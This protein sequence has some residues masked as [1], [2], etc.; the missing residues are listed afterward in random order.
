MQWQRFCHSNASIITRT[1]FGQNATSF[2]CPHCGFVGKSWEPWAQITVPI[3]GQQGGESN[4]VNLLNDQFDKSHQLEGYRCDQCKQE[5]PTSLQKISRCPEILILILG[6]NAWRGN[7][8]TK[9]TTR[10]RFPL[11]GLS[12]DP[13][14]ISLEGQG[15][16]Q[17]DDSF[18][19]P[20]L[21]DCYAVVQHFGA[22]AKEGHYTALV[23]ETDP[24]NGKDIWLEYNDEVVREV[25]NIGSVSQSKNSYVLFYQRRKNKR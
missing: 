22:N 17:L 13:Y 5:G 9:K 24:R 6:R 15:S 19:S 4:L 10:V 14:F 1:F 7:I 20:F 16:E 11:D 12:L 23:K 3:T 18:I 21:Y 25:A 2:T 8:H